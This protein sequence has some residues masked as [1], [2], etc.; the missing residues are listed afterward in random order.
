MIID[1]DKKIDDIYFGGSGSQS[2]CDIRET[3]LAPNEI[4]SLFVKAKTPS[5]SDVMFNAKGNYEPFINSR[6][7]YARTIFEGEFL[8][9]YL[10]NNK[11]AGLPPL[12]YAPEMRIYFY[13]PQ[14]NKWIAK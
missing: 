10:D 3:E 9:I 12:N 1:I 14:E 11:V 6:S 5:I 2:F 8:E 4:V 7:F 13:M